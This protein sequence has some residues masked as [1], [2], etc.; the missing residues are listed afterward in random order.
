MTISEIVT[1]CQ[2]AYG[3]RF[4]VSE[5]IILQFINTIQQIAFN[6]DLDAFL[7]YGDY[8][9]VYQEI[10]LESGGYTNC[11]AADIGKEVTDGTGTGTLIS[12]D[13]TKRKWVVDTS[14]TLTGALTITTGVGAGTLSAQVVSK[15]PYSW[16]SLAPNLGS[17]TPFTTSAGVRRMMG[18]TRI[19]DPQFFGNPVTSVIYDY[20]F[21]V[22]SVDRRSIY[23]N[24]RK[25]DMFK[26]ISFIDEPATE[27][28]TYRWVY[29]MRPPTISAKTTADDA[30]LLI[31]EEFHQTLV[32][33]GVQRLADRTTYGD[34]APEVVL[35]PIMQPF[36][37]MMAQKYTPMGD[38]SNQTSEGQL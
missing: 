5:T 29:Y 33:E 14:D 37:D 9:T 12:Y 21:S 19:T 26:T 16:A 27:A 32:V 1:A 17:L 36:W 22:N 2:A 11:V 30:N 23:E 35:E 7:W 20:G 10:T 4:Q 15:G 25:N 18:V 13:N 31:P 28:E 6:R 38:N 3:A 24:V 8:L 34:M